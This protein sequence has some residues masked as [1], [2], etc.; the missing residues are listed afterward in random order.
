MPLAWGSLSGHACS[1]QSRRARA[2]FATKVPPATFNV[3]SCRPEPQVCVTMCAVISA[4]YETAM[5]GR[6]RTAKFATSVFSR[7]GLVYYLLHMLQ[8]C[9]P[10]EQ[11]L[12][13]YSHSFV[14]NCTHH[15]SA[16]LTHG[17]CAVV[18]VNHFA[19]FHVC[20]MHTFLSCKCT[21]CTNI[22]KI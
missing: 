13:R 14:S 15:V 22:I 8:T 21:L 5:P 20:V 6:T 12:G 11:P 18:A 17:Y 4:T 19:R 2:W 3:S 10:R 16:L 1:L 7:P 9:A